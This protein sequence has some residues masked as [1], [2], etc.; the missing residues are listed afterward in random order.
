VRAA[1]ERLAAD[2][3]LRERLREGGH[4]TAARFDQREF[5]RRVADAHEREAG[6]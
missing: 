6:T 5:D 3:S 2:E 4:D 1:I